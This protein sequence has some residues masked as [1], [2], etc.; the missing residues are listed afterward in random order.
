[1][2]K[3]FCQIF[4]HSERELVF[5]TSSTPTYFDGELIEREPLWVSWRCERCSEFLDL[6]IY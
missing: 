2:K 1:M 4:G 5:T 3:V 6:R